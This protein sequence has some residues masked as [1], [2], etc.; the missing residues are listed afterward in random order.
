[1]NNTTKYARYS[2]NA[3]I[4][5]NTKI[6]PQSLTNNITKI[7]KL[8]AD[9]QSKK[10]IRKP[11]VTRGSVIHMSKNTKITPSS[12]NRNASNTISRN[13]T[14]T[15]RLNIPHNIRNVTPAT[16]YRN[17]L[18][19]GRPIATVRSTRNNSN[20]ITPA[21]VNHDYLKR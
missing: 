7:G 12:D 20:N 10:L 4:S 19:I 14:A 5:N 1:M 18:D 11:T 8:Y 6:S 9:K 21:N 3:I 16:H 13:P 2:M 17:A 15:R